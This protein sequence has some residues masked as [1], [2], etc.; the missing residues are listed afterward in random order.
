MNIDWTFIINKT[1]LNLIYFVGNKFVLPDYEKYPINN[2][3]CLSIP[4]QFYFFLIDNLIIFAPNNLM[5]L[6][7]YRFIKLNVQ[8]NS[9]WL[10]KEN[11]CHNFKLKKKFDAK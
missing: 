2:F 7:R 1:I 4:I 3:I 6:N 5:A 8:L 11:V 9:S 10:S